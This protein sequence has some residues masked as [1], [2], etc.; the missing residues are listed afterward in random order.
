[1]ITKEDIKLLAEYFNTYTSQD[2]AMQKLIAKIE[3]MKQYQD[4]TDELQE[5]MKEENK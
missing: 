4:L 3:K 5:M 1:M 2:P